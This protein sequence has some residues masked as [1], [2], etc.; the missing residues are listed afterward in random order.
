M[1]M[2][3]LINFDI[4]LFSVINN[5]FTH[6][7]FPLKEKKKPN[8]ITIINDDEF[9]KTHQTLLTQ[10]NLIYSDLKI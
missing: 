3:S 6:S 2:T 1:I 10:I 5:I 8:S 9:F 4:F 7:H